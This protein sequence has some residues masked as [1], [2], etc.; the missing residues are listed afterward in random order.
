MD[1]IQT[2]TKR[3]SDVLVHVK[4]CDLC[5]QAIRVVAG[6]AGDGRGI[7]TAFDEPSGEVHEC[8]T[9]PEDLKTEDIMILADD[10]GC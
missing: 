10:C 6:V 1:R 3:T 2:A 5:H 4:E 7:E 8:W 9:L